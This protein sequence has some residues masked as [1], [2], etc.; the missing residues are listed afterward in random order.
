MRTD[1]YKLTQTPLIQHL[2]NTRSVCPYGL[3]GP[4]VGAGPAYVAARGEP[5]QPRIRLEWSRSVRY[6]Y[7][8]EGRVV[9]AKAWLYRIAI[10]GVWPT[11]RGLH[12]AVIVSVVSRPAEKCP[13]NQPVRDV[14]PR[15]RIRNEFANR[16]VK[17][18]RRG[19]IIGSGPL[20]HLRAPA[21]RV[22]HS[23]A[24]LEQEPVEQS[25]GDVRFHAVENAAS[26]S[27]RA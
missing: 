12:S 9:A 15:E 16:V 3:G 22:Q 5:H 21:R 23:I 10:D 8:H 1:T 11:T 6:G 13:L 20:E 24:H 7:H 25:A 14:Y 17:R 27:Y 19:Q 2:S 4:F 18:R 26:L